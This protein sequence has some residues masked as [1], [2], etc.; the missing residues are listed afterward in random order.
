MLDEEKINTLKILGLTEYEARIYASLVKTGPQSA[1]EISFLSK[2]PRTKTYGVLRSLKAKK[3]ISVMSG[4]PE[5]YIANSPELLF[6][7]IEKINKEI[8]ECSETIKKLMIAYESLKYIHPEWP[9]EKR[10]YWIFK[11]GEETFKAF[12]SLINNSL[13][14][15]NILTKSEG[16]VRIYKKHYEELEEAMKRNV[17]IR[18]ITFVKPFNQTIIKDFSKIA[19]IKALEIQFP[20]EYLCIDLKKNVYEVL[21]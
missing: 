17:S 16:I 2:V 12:K 13:S 1:T 18:I 4:K 14:S 8:T 15:I 11:N 19:R 7:L 5:K 6:S 20:F 10:E 3:L 9:I 21:Q